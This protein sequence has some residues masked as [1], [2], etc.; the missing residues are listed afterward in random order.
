MRG[1]AACSGRTQ[2]L[3]T[4]RTVLPPSGA[5]VIHLRLIQRCG[6]RSGAGLGSLQGSFPMETRGNGVP[7]PPERVGTAFPHLQRKV[8]KVAKSKDSSD[9]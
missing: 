8:K 6:V 5:P 9:L 7:I 2:R 1:G 3:E 4:I